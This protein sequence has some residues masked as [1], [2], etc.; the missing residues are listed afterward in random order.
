MLFSINCL[1]EQNV[2]V[3]F[4][5]QDGLL[6]ENAMLISASLNG[7]TGKVI[8]NTLEGLFIL[9]LMGH[10]SSVK[11]ISRSSEFIANK[12]GNGLYSLV[13]IAHYDNRFIFDRKPIELG[14]AGGPFLKIG[15][16]ALFKEPQCTSGD[17]LLSADSLGLSLLSPELNGYQEITIP[18]WYSDRSIGS[19]GIQLSQVQSNYCGQGQL[20]GK[21]IHI[22]ENTFKTRFTIASHIGFDYFYGEQGLKCRISV[23]RSSDLTFVKS[24]VDSTTQ[25]VSTGKGHAFSSAFFQTEQDNVTTMYNSSDVVFQG[26]FL[27]VFAK[28]THST[29]PVKCFCLNLHNLKECRT[30]SC[31]QQ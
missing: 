16:V 11:Y 29:K 26:E 7:E 28:D 27:K 6:S 14:S 3:F 8:D 17:A 2:K 19:A 23:L 22:D 30:C 1:A 20:F 25:I 9:S 31:E 18:S 21:F 4:S 5:T 12:I 13:S 15:V 24:L 10:R